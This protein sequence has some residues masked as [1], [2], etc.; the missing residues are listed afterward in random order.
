MHEADAENATQLFHAEP[1]GKIQSV[2]ISVP[3]ED[4]A[5]TEKCC[6][7]GRRAF[8]QTKR[9]RGAAVAEMRRIG[10]TEESQ[11]GNRQQSRN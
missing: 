4:A 10:D 7:I 11:A 5:V 2:E 9:N 3:G 1:F 8:G 6:G